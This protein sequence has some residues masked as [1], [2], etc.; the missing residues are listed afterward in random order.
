MLSKIGRVWAM[1]AAELLES[2]ISLYQLIYG[3]PLCFGAGSC[4]GAAVCVA[5]ILIALKEWSSSL[6][7]IDA[8]LLCLA[9]ER[10]LT[11]L[12]MSA[13]AMQVCLSMVRCLSHPTIVEYLQLSQQDANLGGFPTGSIAHYG[14][15]SPVV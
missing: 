12:C 4:C 5:L 10:G 2:N 1:P 9:S 6:R 13:G 3:A 14:M 8:A 15:Q 7:D 11:L